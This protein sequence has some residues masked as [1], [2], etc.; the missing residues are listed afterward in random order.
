[1]RLFGVFNTVLKMAVIPVNYGGQSV[2]TGELGSVKYYYYTVYFTQ[3]TTNT[4]TQVCRKFDIAV[5]E[6]S[7]QAT[8]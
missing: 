1:M 5:S 8:K 2:S 7:H 6:M 3:L 4:N